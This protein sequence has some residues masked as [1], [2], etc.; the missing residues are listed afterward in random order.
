MNDDTGT[1]NA[2]RLAVVDGLTTDAVMLGELLRDAGFDRDTRRPF[3]AHEE[4]GVTVFFEPE[5]VRISFPHEQAERHLAVI[6]FPRCTPH[7]VLA[8]VAVA[9][10]QAVDW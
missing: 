10:S 8:H 9:L 1:R 6:D 5:R 7:G 2:R 4:S 3:L